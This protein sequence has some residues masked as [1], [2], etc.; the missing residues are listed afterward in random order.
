MFALFSKIFGM[1]QKAVQHLPKAGV[2]EFLKTASNG[3]SLGVVSIGAVNEHFID[4]VTNQ[5][6]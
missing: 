6:S 4:S 5:R 3:V 1:A 2:A